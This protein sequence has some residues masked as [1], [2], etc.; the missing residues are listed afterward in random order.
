MCALGSC[1]QYVS[2]LNMS[3]CVSAS[4][5]DAAHG[6][7]LSLNM[8]ANMVRYGLVVVTGI[9]LLKSA[10]ESRSYTYSFSPAIQRMNAG[11]LHCLFEIGVVC[12]RMLHYKS[13]KCWIDFIQSHQLSFE[14]PKRWIIVSSTKMPVSI[15]TIYS[16]KSYFFCNCTALY[17]SK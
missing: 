9:L 17:C 11:G 12:R 14:N 16:P 2:I 6:L 3:A 5:T 15:T 13:I 10:A 8:R 1:S 7:S 4:D